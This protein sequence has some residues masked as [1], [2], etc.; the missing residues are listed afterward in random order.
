MSKKTRKKIVRQD[1]IIPAN[2]SEKY[3]DNKLASKS[4]AKAPVAT[5]KASM[6]PQ[7]MAKRYQYVKDDLKT[8]AFIAIPMI[9]GLFILSFFLNV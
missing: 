2:A 8:I 4:T 7:D 5:G 6:P 3:T 9:V 1:L